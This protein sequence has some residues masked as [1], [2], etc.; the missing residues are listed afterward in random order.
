ME[1][2]QIKAEI[3]SAIFQELDGWL[4][5]QSKI[6]GGYEYECKHMIF[7]QRMNNIVLQKGLPLAVLSCFS[8]SMACCL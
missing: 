8:L 3:L 4:E 2:S 7:A 6:T 5:D 1:N